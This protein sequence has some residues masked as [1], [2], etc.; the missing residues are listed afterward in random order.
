MQETE[1]RNI[2]E[3][4]FYPADSS[5]TEENEALIQ[6]I[7]STVRSRSMTYAA[8]QQDSWSIMFSHADTALKVLLPNSVVKVANPVSSDTIV[9]YQNDFINL[10]FF[11]YSATVSEYIEQYDMNA[12]EFDVTDCTVNGVSVHIFRPKSADI[13]TDYAYI[14]AE[15][16]DGTL[17][18]IVMGTTDSAEEEENAFYCEQI[19]ASISEL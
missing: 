19:I 8:D 3:L 18:E 9:E 7:L 12:D 1:G 16:K 10:L 17:L 14:G 4:G 13:S 6:Q 15:G 5:A 2:L 11:A